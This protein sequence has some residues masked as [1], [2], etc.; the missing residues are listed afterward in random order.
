MPNRISH[1]TAQRIA[2]AWMA[3]VDSGGESTIAEVMQEA[4]VET[5]DARNMFRYRRQAEE[6]LGWQFPPLN[7]KAPRFYGPHTATRHEDDKPYS[8]LIFSDA[9]WRTKVLTPAHS[10]LLKLIPEIRPNVVIDNGDSWDGAAISR[11]K[12]N[13]WEE[14]PSLAEELEIVRYHL[15]TIRNHAHGATFYRCLGNHDFRF[16]AYMATHAPEMVGMPSTRI[17]DLFHGWEH[18]ISVVLNETLFVKHRFRNGVHAAHNNVLWAGMSIATGHTHRLKCLPMTNLRGT[19]YGI[20]TGTLADPYG[21]QF[22][23]TE[24]N[25]SNTQSGFVVVNVDGAE[26]HVELVEVKDNK[27]FFRGRWWRA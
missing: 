25:P 17:K 18:S 11:F 6:Y 13:M 7:R 21:E 24:D 5:T 12:P 14:K 20:E 22:F 3:K 10:I 16:E 23:Y 8:V 2:Q 4:G 1:D 19:H 26:I 15:D 9:H 27:A